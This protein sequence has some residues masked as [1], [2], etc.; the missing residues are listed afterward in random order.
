MLLIENAGR[1]R[2][3]S[4]LF[5]AWLLT[6]CHGN[7]QPSDTAFRQLLQEAGM[8]YSRPQDFESLLPAANPLLPYEYAARSNDGRLEIRYAVRPLA[9][10]KIEY[11]DPHTSAP[12]P[13]HMFNMLFAS[14]AEQLAHGGDAPRREYTPQQAKALFN[15]DWAAGSIFDAS[16]ELSDDYS[17][18]LLIAI[19]KNGK[20]DAY[21]LYL[22]ND[23]PEVKEL[24]NSTLSSL[25]FSS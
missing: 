11:D 12:E 1:L 25:K 7:T 23:Y 4:C 20:A 18:G 21:M 15:A 14:L 3:I 13:N 24:I 5:L 6:G 10:I 17:Q 22:F 2:I 19:H 9:R 8:Q 16:N